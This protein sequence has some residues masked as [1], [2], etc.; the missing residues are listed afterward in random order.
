VNWQVAPGHRLSLGLNHVNDEG[1]R[2]LRPNFVDFARSGAAMPQTWQRD[3]LTLGYRYAGTADM[4][5]VEATLFSDDNRSERTVTATGRTYGEQVKGRGV[6]ASIGQRLGDHKLKFGLNHHAYESKAL[7]PAN[8]GTGPYGNGSETASVSGVFAEDSVALAARWQLSAGLR[9]DQY[10]YRDDHGQHFS[11]TGASP[12]LGLQYAATDALHLHASA[13]SPVRGAGLKESFLL[14]NGPG[15]RNVAGLQAERARN[16]AVGFDAAL[17]PVVLRGEAFQQRI[18][19]YIT[20]GFD[21]GAN[22][23]RHNAGELVSRG[24]EL[25]LDTRLGALQAGASVAHSKPKLN[26]V[27]LSDGDFGAG[28]ATGRTWRLLLAYA[29]PTM[30]IDLGWTT[31]VVESLAYAPASAPTQQLSKAGYS[32]HDVHAVWRPASVKGLQLKLA[33]NNLFDKFYYDQATYAYHTGFG[34]VLGYPE[35][36]RDLRVELAWQF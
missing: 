18:A 26:G 3:Q 32:V 22:A 15:Y 28:V 20:T 23:I 24:Y 2:F 8:V 1:V 25:G 33:V 27:A 17:G 13:G 14:D 30:G 10:R 35:P 5:T 6:N 36:G 9:L 16:L 19:R 11:S 4:P 29:L 34:K 12:S 21:A 7:N 31:R